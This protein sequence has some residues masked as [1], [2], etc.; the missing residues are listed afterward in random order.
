MAQGH[1][2]KLLGKHITMNEDTGGYTAELPIM[3]IQLGSMAPK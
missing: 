2:T 3:I 1:T